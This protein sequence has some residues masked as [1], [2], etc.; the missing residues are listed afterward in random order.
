MVFQFWKFVNPDKTVLIF[1]LPPHPLQN[2]RPYFVRSF[3]LWVGN[4]KPV[5]KT[6]RRTVFRAL[7]GIKNGGSKPPDLLLPQTTSNFTDSRNGCTYG[8]DLL[9]AN[10]AGRRDADPYKLWFI[11]REFC[12]G[13]KPPPYAYHKQLLTLRTGVS[14]SLRLWF[15]KSKYKVNYFNFALCIKKADRG[16][17]TA[18]NCADSTK[19]HP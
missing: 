1:I 3:L 10:L 6:V 11:V 15:K 2:K 9:S 19:K 8:F 4:R 5:K 17:W 13:S 14:P 7:N 18:P 16:K 12:G